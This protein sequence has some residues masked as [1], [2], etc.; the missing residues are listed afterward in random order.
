MLLVPRPVHRHAGFPVPPG[1]K[2]AA[3]L[4]P[5]PTQAGQD[6][7]APPSAPLGPLAVRPTVRRRLA[8]AHLAAKMT[9]RLPVPIGTPRGTPTQVS[10]ASWSRPSVLGS[11]PGR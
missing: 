9:E 4:S 2:A 11:W 1:T 7:A 6:R 10:I 8:V 3:G 5:Q